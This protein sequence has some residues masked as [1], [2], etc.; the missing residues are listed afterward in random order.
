[1][2]R[3]QIFVASETIRVTR[4]NLSGMKFSVYVYGKSY[5]LAV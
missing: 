4:V 2:E 5:I 1:L 3:I